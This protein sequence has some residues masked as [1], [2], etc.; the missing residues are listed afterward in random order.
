VRNKKYIVILSEAGAH[1][2]RAESKDLWLLSC[3]A[4]DSRRS[5]RHPSAGKRSTRSSRS[6]SSSHLRRCSCS[7]R[8]S[9]PSL[10]EYSY[11][12]S[13]VQFSKSP[14]HSERTGAQT[15]F[16]LGVV[17]EESAVAFVFA[18]V[19]AQAATVILIVD[20]VKAFPPDP[21]LWPTDPQP[22]TTLNW[23]WTYV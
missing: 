9:R 3:A 2:A 14:C 22:P 21:N 4:Y 15:F 18:F 8:S 16:S 6:R 23:Y 5:G 7:C 20:A 13:I 11:I 12:Y 19:F 17:S 1:F 10:T